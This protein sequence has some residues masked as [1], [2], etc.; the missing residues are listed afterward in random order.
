[1]YQQALDYLKN[2]VNARSKELINAL[3]HKYRDGASLDE[4]WF[5]RSKLGYLE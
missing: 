5:Q 2:G 3:L 4:H 1:V